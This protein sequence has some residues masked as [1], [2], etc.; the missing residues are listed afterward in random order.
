[1]PRLNVSTLLIIVLGGILVLFA[2]PMIVSL[3]IPNRPP[4]PGGE[5]A[6]KAVYIDTVSISFPNNNLTKYIVKTLS[7]AGYD[8]TVINGTEV[9]V[10]LMKT[11]GKNGYKLVIFRMHSTYTR[12]PLTFL[13]N[14][15]VVLITGERYVRDKY[16]TEQF[17]DMV[18]PST[19]VPELG[20]AYGFFSI[21][22]IFIERLEGGFKGA[23]VLAMGC[24][25]LYT[26]SMAKAFIDKGAL[27]YIGWD[28]YVT[29]SHMDKALEKLV[30]LLLKGKTVDKAVSEVNEEVGADPYYGSKLVYYPEAAGKVV[31]AQPRS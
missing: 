15:T 14:E 23:I 8:I 6:L 29:P 18:V 22:P 16:L 7:R 21:T 1:M 17:Y 10:N 2:A 5:E 19:L 13:P 25:T 26:K 27:A 12:T 20:I 28:G 9:T 11:L 3:F 30:D 4:Q 24:H 31:L